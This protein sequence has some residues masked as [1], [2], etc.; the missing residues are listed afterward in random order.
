MILLASHIWYDKTRNGDILRSA[1]LL[2]WD[3]SRHSRDMMQLWTE[4]DGAFKEY[5]LNPSL[6]AKVKIDSIEQEIGISGQ[7]KF[8]SGDDWVGTVYVQ[9]CDPW[10]DSWGY[11]YVVAGSKGWV[12]FS[13]L[14]RGY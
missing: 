8:S 1:Q 11:E 3:P 14:D 9:Y 7:I 13:Q 12:Y 2:D 10:Y 6:K 4:E 5:T